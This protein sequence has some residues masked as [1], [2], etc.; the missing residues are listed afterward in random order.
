MQECT[1]AQNK[2]TRERT[3]VSLLLGAGFRTGVAADLPP[4]LTAARL[5]GDQGV[6]GQ[7]G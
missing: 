1:D 7:A 6:G 5:A 4:S 3:F 2:Q